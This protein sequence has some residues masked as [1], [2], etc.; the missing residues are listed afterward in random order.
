MEQTE[1]RVTIHMLVSPDGFIARYP[2]AD[3]IAI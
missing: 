2:A 3:I 1:S